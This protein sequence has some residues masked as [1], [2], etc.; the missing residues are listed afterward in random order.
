MGTWLALDI[1]KN[2]PCGSKT[3][4]SD[5]FCR[6]TQLRLDRVFIGL[7]KYVEGS[8]IRLGA[9]RTVPNTFMMSKI[10]SLAPQTLVYLNLEP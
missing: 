10:A 7:K 5:E 8:N 1:S 6:F 9:G 3:Q 2:H 4:N